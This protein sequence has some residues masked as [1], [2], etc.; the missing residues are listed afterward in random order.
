LNTLDNKKNTNLK[1]E[2]RNQVDII[3]ENTETVETLKQQVDR[4]LE[5]K[6]KK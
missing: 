1:E 4:L 3:I 2:K 6:N 5:L